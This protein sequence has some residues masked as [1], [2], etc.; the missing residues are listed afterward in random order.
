MVVKMLKKPLGLL[1]VFLL[2]VSLGYFVGAVVAWTQV[3]GGY[4][5]LQAFSEQQAVELTYNEDGELIDRG[6]VEGVEAIVTLLEDDWNFPVVESDLDPDDPLVNTATEYMFQMATIV[7][8]TLE[9]TQTVVLTADDLVNEDGSPID[10]ITCNGETIE[11][12]DPVPEDGITCEFEV[13]GRYW[14]GF[15]R[16]DPVQAKAR[17]L[18]W[19]GTVHGLVGELGVGAVTHSTLMLGLGIAGLLAGLGVVCLVMG[20]AFLWHTRNGL[21]AATPAAG[22]GDVQG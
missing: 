11:V 14:T 13:D 4:G 10:E 21:V 12:P 2:L 20:V 6:T 9:G 16:T 1:G 17:D 8:H 15:D 19:S 5:S 7:H 18:A 22:G 3:Q